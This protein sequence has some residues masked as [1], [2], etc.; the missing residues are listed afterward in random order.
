[1][2]VW[3]NTSFLVPL[4]SSVEHEQLRTEPSLSWGLC[5]HS[6]TAELCPDQLL[7]CCKQVASSAATA[8][9]TYNPAAPWASSD[10]TAARPWLLTFMLQGQQLGWSCSLSVPAA[11][12]ACCNPAE[13]F[14][15]LQLP[16]GPAVQQGARS[17]PG[18]LTCC[19]SDGSHLPGGTW[20]L[21]WA[22]FQS[23]NNA[24]ENQSVPSFISDVPSLNAKSGNTA[25]FYILFNCLNNC[26]GYLLAC[27]RHLDC[28]AFAHMETIS[29]FFFLHR[30]NRCSPE[31]IC[32]YKDTI[33]N[34]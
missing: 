3:V 12:S 16:A 22:A 25:M 19:C 2:G 27:N 15:S 14:S 32:N 6:Q 28:T 11:G 8:E 7:D 4:S 13:L 23:L 34:L 9:F 26:S 21:S 31:G 20:E 1:M 17:K 29:P 10:S 5:S 33:K 24:A 18:T 30:W